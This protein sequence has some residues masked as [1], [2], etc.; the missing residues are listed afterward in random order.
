MS[1][2]LPHETRMT[3]L[4]VDGGTRDSLRHLSTAE[5]RRFGMPLLAYVQPHT[6]E[7]GAPG[8]VIHAADGTHLAEVET[9]DDALE[10]AADN[11]VVLVGTQ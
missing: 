9:F 2:L 3:A 6:N 5:F 8:W 4:R 11:Q 1:H 10:L 7:D